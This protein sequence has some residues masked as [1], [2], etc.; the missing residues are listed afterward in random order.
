MLALVFVGGA[1]IALLIVIVWATGVPVTRQPLWVVL[2]STVV[3]QVGMLAAAFLLGPL[4]YGN[5]GQLFGRRRLSTLAL[6]GW[7][8]LGL[9]ASLGVSAAYVVIADQ[10]SEDL[11]PDP[12]PG[13]IDFAEARVLAF[14]VVALLAPFAEEVFFRGFLFAG[15]VKRYGFWVAAVLSASVF[16]LVHLE[17]ARTIPALLSGIIFGAVYYRSGSLWPAVLAHTGQNAIAF[18]L[19]P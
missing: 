19:A 8:T 15:F 3:L 2:M 11:V 4:R 7:A 6:F 14:V 9:V 13:G 10:I 17:L 16:A 1:A 5:P 12:V 18:G